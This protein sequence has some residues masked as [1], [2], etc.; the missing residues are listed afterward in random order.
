MAL[1]LGELAGPW[2]SFSGPSSWRLGTATSCAFLE[3]IPGDAEV[4]RGWR[5]LLPVGPGSPGPR[6]AASQQVGMGSGVKGVARSS[7]ST[8][9]EFCAQD[10]GFTCPPHGDHLL[11]HSLAS[12]CY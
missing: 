10:A 5:L 9:V 8:F 12:D 1:G 7:V 11:S 6:L 3:E 4:P 2:W